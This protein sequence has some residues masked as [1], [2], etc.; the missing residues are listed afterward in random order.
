MRAA[1]RLSAV[2]IARL[3]EP[4]RYADG[5]NLWLQITK[6]KTKSWLFRYM[7]DGRERAMGLGPVDI[8][9]LADARERARQARRLLLDGRDPIDQRHGERSSARLE[10]AKAITFRDAAERYVDAHEASWRNEKHRAQ[11]RSTL[12]MYAYPV[13]GGLPVSA[14][15]TALVLKVIEPIWKT[16]AETASRV[17]GRIETILSWATVRGYRTGDNPARW[18]GHLDQILPKRSKIAPVKHHAAM[19]YRDVPAFLTK[20]R[21]HGEA[22]SAAALEFTVLTA[23]RTNE[24]IGAR[25]EEIDLEEGLWTIPKTRIKTQRAHR[26][27]LPQRC[28]DLL[29]GLPRVADGQGYLFPG[30]RAGRA[31]SNMAMAMLLRDVVGTDVTVHGFRSSFKDWATEQTHHPR[32]IVEAA[33]AHVVGDK[34]EAAYRRGDALEKRRALM[35]DWADY[36]MKGAT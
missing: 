19:R 27:A 12:E 17:R 13:V 33:L 31:L 21:Q 36:C 25:W 10:A 2:K 29:K 11:W 9:P 6:T 35:A 15:D 22:I 18:R 5:G 1:N 23:A 3:T 34:V 8:V 14:M 28:L 30:A 26:V 7:R 32:D 20:L 24:T 4:G 16:K